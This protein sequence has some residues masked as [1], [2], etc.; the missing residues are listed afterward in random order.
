[1]ISVRRQINEPFGVSDLKDFMELNWKYIVIVMA[2]L[3]M[4]SILIVWRRGKKN[5][6]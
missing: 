6:S 4:G 2:L 5:E 3:L 1:M